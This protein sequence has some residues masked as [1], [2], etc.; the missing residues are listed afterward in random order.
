[1]QIMKDEEPSM[2]DESLANR[3]LDLEKE[4]AAVRLEQNRLV[5]IVQV[6]FRLDEEHT[7][8]LLDGLDSVRYH[9]NR[10]DAIIKNRDPDHVVHPR[11]RASRPWDSKARALELLSA[12]IDFIA[13][14]DRVPRT[15]AITGMMDHAETEVLRDLLR[16]L[17]E[18]DHPKPNRRGRPRKRATP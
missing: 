8:V 11:S 17:E 16:Q 14:R 13:A 1:M 12:T 7:A 6:I 4:L 18:R 10:I 3:V 9:S 15:D 2:T 5:D